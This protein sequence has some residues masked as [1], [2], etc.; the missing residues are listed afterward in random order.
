[1]NCRRQINCQYII[2]IIQGIHYEAQ[3]WVR[4]IHNSPNGDF[5]FL[6]AKYQW[7]HFSVAVQ[8]YSYLT[9]S[10]QVKMTPMSCE[11][12]KIELCSRQLCKTNVL[13][14]GH[15]SNHN[16]N[17]SVNKW[18]MKNT[19]AIKWNWKSGLKLAISKAHACMHVCHDLAN[20]AW[21][22]LDVG[23][24]MRTQRNIYRQQVPIRWLWAYWSEALSL[25][26]YT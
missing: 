25:P 24:I 11:K 16:L 4:S 15:V 7:G 12:T 1:M 21:L 5:K 10:F 17:T 19:I 2:I 23:G 26:I 6:P 13:V 14:I 8:V 18:T 3:N 20:V 22:N 9:S